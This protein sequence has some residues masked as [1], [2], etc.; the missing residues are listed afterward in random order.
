MSKWTTLYKA[1]HK[2]AASF[3]TYSYRHFFKRRIDDYW[4]EFSDETDQTKLDALYKVGEFYFPFDKFVKI[5]AVLAEGRVAAG[6]TETT[7]RHRQY[8]PRLQARHREVNQRNQR[9][10]G[11]SSIN[12]TPCAPVQSAK[13]RR[14]IIAILREFFFSFRGKNRRV[15]GVTTGIF[16]ALTRILAPFWRGMHRQITYSNQ[17]YRKDHG[18]RGEGHDNRFFW[19]I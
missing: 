15:S 13:R 4:K 6:G 3:E 5:R 1:L 11:I 19:P 16:D 7:G 9:N 12:S 18:G 8:V 10:S 14:T 17:K 2:E